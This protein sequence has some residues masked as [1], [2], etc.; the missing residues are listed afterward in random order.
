MGTR[1][2]IYRWAVLLVL[3]VFLQSTTVHAQVIHEVFLPNTDHELNVY[4]IFG[5]EP[6]RT[7]MIIGGIQGD[8]PGSYLT[9]DLYADIHLKKGNLIVVPRANFYSILLDRRE[10]SG[11]RVACHNQADGRKLWEQ[12]VGDRD[13]M[14]LALVGLPGVWVQVFAGKS[15][16]SPDGWYTRPLSYRALSIKDGRKLAEYKLDA[17]PVWDSMAAA[18]GRLYLCT[19][20]G[21][22]RCYK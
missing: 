9:A 21:Q 17:P 14:S 1:Q 3:A 2:N 7:I 16:K 5:E 18:G 6:G 11:I 10:G 19:T 4:R 13:E 12:R 22:I 15:R 20:D 8:E